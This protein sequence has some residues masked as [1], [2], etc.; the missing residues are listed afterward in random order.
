MMERL[1]TLSA[2]CGF[3]NDGTCFERNPDDE[4]SFVH[5][6]A[7]GDVVAWAGRATIFLTFERLA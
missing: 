6:T 1:R 3:A 2:A 7:N 4:R 5:E